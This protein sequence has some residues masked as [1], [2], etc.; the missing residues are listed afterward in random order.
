[1]VPRQIPVN[2]KIA[3]TN[4]MTLGTGGKWLSRPEVLP[5]GQD[6]WRVLSR[7]PEDQEST[8]FPQ[9]VSAPLW[10]A[11]LL[12]PQCIPEILAQASYLR[13]AASFPTVEWWAN[14]GLYTRGEESWHVILWDN[15]S[16]AKS[17][18][19]VGLVGPEG[20]RGRRRGRQTSRC[21]WHQCGKTRVWTQH[22]F[23]STADNVAL[24]RILNE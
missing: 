22:N 14:R 9:S 19:G 10:K 11:W 4:T 8:L 17:T 7:W 21:R 23:L 13:L 20:R 3:I 6:A 16:V 12:L 5:H 1:M 2:Y 15:L 18:G 24:M